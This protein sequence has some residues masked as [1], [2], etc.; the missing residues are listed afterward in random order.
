MRG[1]LRCI[2]CPRL[3]LA[4]LASFA[5]VLAAD[6]GPALGLT[7][8]GHEANNTI[9]VRGTGVA[10]GAYTIDGG[11]RVRFSGIRSL[12]IDGVGGHDVCRII[13]PQ[14]GLFAP[15]GGIACN[16]GNRRGAPRKGVLDVS[17][18]KSSSSTYSPLRGRPGAGTITARLGRLVQVIRFSGLRPIRDTTSAVNY[19]LNDSATG[20]LVELVDG[21]DVGEVTIESSTGQFESTTIANKQNVTV[22]ANASG[23]SASIDVDQPV[24]GLASLTINALGQIAVDEALLA[25]DSLTLTSSGGDVVQPGGPIVLGQGALSASAG[26][27]VDLNRENTVGAFSAHAA[28]GDVDFSQDGFGPL[29]VGT[30]TATQ[31]A[32]IGD[33]VGGLDVN[34]GVS[35]GGSSQVAMVAFGPISLAGGGAITGGPVRLE[36]PSMTLAGGS[37]KAS[38]SVTLEPAYTGEATS[39]VRCE[40]G[41][42][43]ARERP[44]RDQCGR[45]TGDRRPGRRP[46]RSHRADL[47]VGRGRLDAGKRRRPH[48]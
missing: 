47:L 7:L 36:A 37:V 27:Q 10:S 24:A 23:D 17:G 29:T 2:G 9:V 42:R 13:D 46:D 35:G 38:G 40:R 33:A 31:G 19:T 12:T 48:A 43:P 30:V 32:F 45:R 44:G 22:N 5:C 16:G 15:P 11:P 26:G 41:F 14:G 1:V 34:G 6:A 20:D 25:G 39:G 28:D 3:V 21:P 4:V 8:R 18:G